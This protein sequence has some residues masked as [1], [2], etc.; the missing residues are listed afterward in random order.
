METGLLMNGA[1]NAAP[2]CT[3]I[4]TDDA[5]AH[6]PTS[7]VEWT[8]PS[9]V[10]ANEQLRQI[11]EMQNRQFIELLK[12]VQPSKSAGQGSITLPK[13]NP[14]VFGVDAISWCSTVDV[15][16]A[17]NPLEG[18]ALIVALSKSMGGC[19][20]QWLS[21]I[22]FA[23]ITWQQFRD[24][25]V[26]RFEGVET[27]AAILM[28]ILNG[29]PN[30]NECISVYASRLVTSLMHK[31]KSQTIEEI[32]IAVVLAH[33]ARF[34]NNLQRLLFK[35]NIRTR[36]ELQQELR[37]FAFGKRKFV[38]E[39]PPESKKYK[40]SPNLKCHFCGKVG[41]KIADCRM[42]R[43]KTKSAMKA[44]KFSDSTSTE[45]GRS[46]L[47]CFRC[48]EVGH[49]ASKCSNQ[50]S[51]NSKSGFEKRVNVCEIIEPKGVLSQSVLHPRT[52]VSQEGRVDVNK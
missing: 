42:K 9:S 8:P 21:Q 17:D 14:D 40:P 38:S 34:D 7:E 13:F 19:A 15:I 37:A 30:D 46:P 31:W 25:F 43:D 28:N 33:S 3:D 52:C 16:M 5:T 35:T 26:Q 2:N 39:N 6:G 36:N 24:L 50:S 27:S 22:S 18:S 12:A 32:A 1:P 47:I 4:N 11:L 23:G 29:H 49:I 45:R 10:N 44:G 48:G 20:S 51:S 41:H